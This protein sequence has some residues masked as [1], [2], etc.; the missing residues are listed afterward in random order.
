MNMKVLENPAT[1]RGR[2]TLDL[3]KYRM[4]DVVLVRRREE[5]TRAGLSMRGRFLSEDLPR[6]DRFS[7]R[8]PRALSEEKSSS[9]VNSNA[10]EWAP[11]LAGNCSRLPRAEDAR[12]RKS[13]MPV[14]IC[15]TSVTV[16][17]GQT[18]SQL[19]VKRIPL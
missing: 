2:E 19:P 12:K 13:V 6:C 5:T 17:H 15:V 16:Y 14:A 18:N 10:S 4:K 7:A 9:R 3:E 11:K 8:R 1:L